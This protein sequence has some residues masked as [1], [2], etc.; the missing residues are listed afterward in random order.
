[1]KITEKFLK[2]LREGSNEIFSISYHLFSCMSEEGLEDFLQFLKEDIKTNENWFYDFHK[3]MRQTDFFQSC[4]VRF[5]MSLLND[6]EKTEYESLSKL[7]GVRGFLVPSEDE[8]NENNLGEEY[9][10]WRIL[11]RKHQNREEES[12]SGHLDMIFWN[13]IHMDSD[14]EIKKFISKF[15]K[16]LEVDEE[17]EAEENKQVPKKSI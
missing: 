4:F 17:F 15:F 9:K 3:S 14:N 10:R 1:M 11:K 5:E 13:L 6:E 2:E 8:A 7:L 12:I 16:H